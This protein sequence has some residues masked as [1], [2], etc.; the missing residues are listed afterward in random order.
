MTELWRWFEHHKRA[1]PFR[2]NRDPYAIL[3]SEVLAQQT[4]MEALLPFYARFMQAFPTVRALAASD[5]AEVLAVWAGLGY[6]ARARN[7]RR[8]CQCVVREYDGVFPAD[9]GALRAL[10]GVGAYTAGALASIAFGLPEPAVD[11]N[12]RRVYARLFAREG[13]DVE[14]FVRS[15]MREEEPAVVTEALMELGALV[16]VPRA[17]RCLLCPVAPR[18][19]AYRAG[20]VE[21]FPVRAEKKPK[22]VEAR[23][24][25]L[26]YSP[27][28]AVLV[29]QRTERLLHGLWEF[30]EQRELLNAGV[31]CRQVYRLCA[32]RHVFTHIVWEMEGW[33]CEGDV[34]AL[35]EGYAWMTAQTVKNFAFPS[36]MRA[37]LAL[38]LFAE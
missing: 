27:S 5:E 4:R 37:F 38:D 35:P 11:G 20:T 7:L 24:V 23:T 12:V 26:V 36:A 15:L 32:A 34:G 31:Y 18:C 17:P 6:Y 14:G 25:C 10:P 29:R 2:E 28:G 21:L 9:V 3:V 30:P 22:R 16:C 1:L 33:R 13:G 19:K 8:A